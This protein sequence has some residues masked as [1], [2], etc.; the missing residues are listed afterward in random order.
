[1]W[2]LLIADDEPKIRRGLSKVL[3][4]QE[5]GIELV[6]EAEHGL[7]ALEM[8]ERLSPDLLF[9]DICMPHLNG[10]EFIERLSDKHKQ[11]V[12]IVISGH[13]EFSYA[14][15]ALKLKVF[16][17]ILKPVMKGKLEQAVGKA[18]EVLEQASR[19]EQRMS[20]MDRQFHS[21]SIALRDAFLCKWMEGRAAPE[22]AARDAAY[23]KLDWPEGTS[24]IV[25][26]VLHHLDT[27]KSRRIWDKGLLEFA[28]KNIAEELLRAEG[29]ERGVVF[30]DRKG[31][32]VVLGPS[33]CGMDWSRY[34]ARMQDQ[35][36]HLLE[37]TIML[38]HGEC[39]GVA[40]HAPQLYAQ[41]V[42]RVGEKD[43]LTPIVLLTRRYIER[44]YNR[45]SLTLG[46]VADGVQ[47]SPSYLSKQL[48]RELGLSFIDY[49]TEVRIRKAIQLMNDPHAKVYEIA[50]K[51]GYS[52][53]H[54][55][56]N[57]F[58]K[59][60]GTSPMLYKKGKRL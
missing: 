23:H 1:M 18:L 11:S 54:Y 48:K 12:I 26:K 24:M 45:A 28:L 33:G 46:D 37:K 5:M 15:Q 41:L 3:P 7:Q 51:V 31:H 42:R 20:W 30:S 2:K 21:N 17:Y 47:V 6:G 8:A 22:E 58:K 55:F 14:Q 59:M 27:G 32:T 36:E 9:V 38:E 35:A 50:E 40:A 57:A 13:D 10:L 49:L 29:C 56:S 19:D 39:D 52:S 25:I 16:D 60:T 34:G 53:Q 44:N 43:N 4:W